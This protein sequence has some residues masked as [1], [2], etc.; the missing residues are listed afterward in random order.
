MPTNESFDTL[1]RELTTEVTARVRDQVQNSIN[2]IVAQRISEL[3]TPDLIFRTII[4]RVDQ[5]IHEFAPDP[6]KFDAKV[7]NASLVIVDQMNTLARER[8]EKTLHNMLTSIDVKGIARDHIG[9]FLSSINKSFFPD[10]YIP[11]SAIN[12]EGFVISGNN[13]NGGIIKNFSSSGIDDRANSCKMTILDQGVVFE[14]TLYSSRI[15]VK[16]DVVIDGDLL[17]KGKI[18]ESCGAFQDLIRDSA[19]RVKQIMGPEI[20]DTF[21][22]SVFDRIKNE[23]IEVNNLIVNGSPLIEGRKLSY[24]I[25][26]SNL[27]SVGMLRD[28]QTQGEN[29]LSETLYVT[30][31]R[32]GVNTMDPVTA[33]SIWD[34]EVELAIGKQK[35]NTARIA[36]QRS[37]NLVL[38]SNN[39]DNIVCTPDGNIAVNAIKIGDTMVSSSAIPPNY[40]APNGAIVFNSN[41]NLGGPIGWVSL[42]LARWANFGIID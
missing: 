4:N 8:I 27:Q 38:G 37:S 29:L 36:A 20:I 2:D 15:E 39:R 30:K 19:A 34:E 28:L 41:P 23:G 22:V 16:G 14:E 33:L 25:V 35:Q 17:I 40:D 3:V 1:V 13:I 11:G 7:E 12:K 21:Q 6:S 42:G 5:R 32:V 10:N 31:N 24:G 18:P 26:D 9:T